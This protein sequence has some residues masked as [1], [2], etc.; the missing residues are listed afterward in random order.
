MQ[1]ASAWSHSSHVLKLRAT[2]P[3]KFI[4][5]PSR[6]HPMP[7]AVV[8]KFALVT[9]FRSRELFLVQTF[10]Y[11]FQM[12]FGLIRFAGRTIATGLRICIQ[13]LAALFLKC[14]C[15]Q[16]IDPAQ[17]CALVFQSQLSGL[18]EYANS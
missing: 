9:V 1:P 8:A 15:S 6:G 12:T 11:G 3:H 16:R 14:A 4:G 5:L 10:G 18:F 7:F 13:N 2:H 17:V